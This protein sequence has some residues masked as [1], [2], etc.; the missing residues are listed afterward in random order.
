[1]SILSGFKKVKNYILTSSGYQLLSRWTSS[2]T[3]E[4][5]DG[6][7]AQTKLGDINGIAKTYID[8]Q[9]TADSSVAASAKAVMEGLS[10]ISDLTNVSAKNVTFD[11]SNTGL[12][13]KNAQEAITEV[14]GK[15][16]KY[17][18][19]TVNCPASTWC[20]IALP[21]DILSVDK[22]INVYRP[23]DA[24]SN[25][26]GI[27]WW[28]SAGRQITILRINTNGTNLIIEDKAKTIKLRIWF[29]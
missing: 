19:I 18:D 5:D 16:P 7:T 2:Q 15:L 23:V 3:V 12:S 17:I 13:A 28:P 1:M 8:M 22:I 24:D 27:I 26:Y 20:N 9:K 10:N 21:D 4:F 25:V 11:N 14:N 29:Y 6:K